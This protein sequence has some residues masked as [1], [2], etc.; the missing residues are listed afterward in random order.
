MGPR[1]LPWS[2]V[3]CF[4]EVWSRTYKP[5]IWGTAAE[6]EVHHVQYM[7]CLSNVPFVLPQVDIRRQ[8]TY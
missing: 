3:W 4:L 2:G 8:E 5:F 7:V 1:V 6:A